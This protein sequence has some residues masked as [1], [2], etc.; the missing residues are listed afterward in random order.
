M[1]LAL[2]V[3]WVGALGA[4][5]LIVDLDGLSGGSG[6]APSDAA[7]EHPDSGSGG[8]G[9]AGAGGGGGT[10]GGGGAAGGGP[11]EGGA[12]DAGDAAEESPPGDAALLDPFVQFAFNSAPNNCSF[13][14]QSVSATFGKPQTAG[15]LNV[16]V[17]GWYD[18]SASI[19]GVSDSAGNT[20]SLAVG[21]TKTQS[22]SSIQQAIYV[23]SAIVAAPSNV[24]TVAFTQSADS[25]DLRVLEYAGYSHIDQ[26]SAASGTT[27]TPSAGLTTRFA[28][29]VVVAGVT[30]GGSFASSGPGEGS[31]VDPCANFAEDETVPGA[32]SITMSATLSS[33]QGDSTWVI[34]LV[35]LH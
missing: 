16:V 21:P 8:A 24:V 28:G 6:G 34:D 27:T 13:Q 3:I 25:P 22:G 30:T 1:R 11:A 26:T 31:H 10:G 4:C 19:A 29:E 14:A 15:N 7:L 32:Q 33:F 2:G 12:E 20:Y 17:I 9:G 35:S 23:A 18:L 5:S